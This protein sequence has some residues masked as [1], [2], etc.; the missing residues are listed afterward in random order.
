MVFAAWLADAPTVG[1][2]MDGC[3]CVDGGE[4]NGGW[5]F[6]LVLFPR[7]LMVNGEWFSTLQYSVESAALQLI[8]RS[9][10]RPRNSTAGDLPPFL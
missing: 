8:L 3:A 10:L 7:G 6:A 5:Q 4:C 1:G 9:H 2:R